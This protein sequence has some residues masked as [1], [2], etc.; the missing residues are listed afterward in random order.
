MTAVIRFP[1]CPD[2][3]H[4]RGL[5]A[6]FGDIA[7]PAATIP[8]HR[9]LV[10]LCYTNR[11]GSNYL[12]EALHSGGRLNLADELLNADEVAADVRRHGHRSFAAFL[13]SHLRWRAVAGR[14]ALKA[15]V[16]HLEVLGRAGVLDHCR[17][18]LRYVLITRR[19]LLGQAISA[20]IAAQTGQWTSNMTV[21]AAPDRLTFSRDRIAAYMAAFAADNAAWDAYFAD[22]G[23]TPARVIYEDL[24][25]DPARSI[26]AVRRALGIA[27]IT[28]DATRVTLRRQAG[29][30]NARW[31]ELFLRG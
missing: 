9:T 11:S 12:A 25:A 5:A 21:E 19:D 14:I 10:L 30:L 31:R 29:A 7:V 2:N 20:E 28:F 13:A 8:P 23:I 18:T 27:G 3:P 22:N 17:A 15:A 16:L 26:A 6:L 24:V 4:L 1:T